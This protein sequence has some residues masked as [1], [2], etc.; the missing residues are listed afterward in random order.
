MKI[1][2]IGNLLEEND[3]GDNTDFSVNQLGGSSNGKIRAD[4]IQKIYSMSLQNINEGGISDKDKDMVRSTYGEM[5]C[6]SVEIFLNAVN[7]GAND[8]LY[9]LGSGNGKVVMQAFA[10]TDVRKAYGI[11]FYPERSYNSEFALK[12]FYKLYP[13]YLSQNRLISYQIA[14]IKDLHYLDDATVIY[15][16]STCYPPELL[17]V[18]LEKVRN[19]KNIRCIVTHKEYPAYSQIL[20][21]KSTLNLPCT[22]SPNLTWNMY[23]K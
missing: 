13:E 20:P 16:C 3:N 15:M 22:W 12:N 2:K 18:V 9:D 6:D 1:Y 10:N 14:N 7:L 17:E 19:S 4:E 23:C 11:E 21:K 8:V 5:L